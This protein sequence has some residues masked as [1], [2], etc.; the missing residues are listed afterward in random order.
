MSSKFFFFL[1]ESLILR[2]VHFFES[3]LDV[4]IGNYLFDTVLSGLARCLSLMPNLH[5]IQIDIGLISTRRSL[6]NVFQRTFKKYSY[7]QIRNVFVMSLS[8]S[9]IASCPEARRVGF[10]QL[11]QPESYYPLPPTSIGKLYF[12]R[13]EVFDDFKGLIHENN[14]TCKRTR[15]YT[16]SI[17]SS[18]ILIIS[19]FLKLS[20]I[21][22]QTFTILRFGCV[23]IHGMKLRFLRLASTLF[24]LR[25][26]V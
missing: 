13:L 25:H 1:L 7:P 8:E 20:S 14:T 5:T 26:L 3:Y 15:F 24:F 2:F 23:N 19:K 21:A 12:P 16:T 6:G 4:L 22:S 9:L 17:C 10:T 11:K 18:R